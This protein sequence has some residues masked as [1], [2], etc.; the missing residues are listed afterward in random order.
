L[1]E[2]GNNGNALRDLAGAGMI[3]ALVNIIHSFGISTCQSL[4]FSASLLRVPPAM[5]GRWSVS[6]SNRWLSASTPRYTVLAS[7]WSTGAALHQ[8]VISRAYGD[9]I[10]V[11]AEEVTEEPLKGKLGLYVQVDAT[12]DLVALKKSRQKIY[13]SIEVH[14]S[15]ADT[16]RSLFDG[17][18]LYR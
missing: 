11:K 7:I 18:G 16:G 13:H 5:V 1:S 12:D 9:V 4:N 3:E 14:P 8:T 10:A 6:T 2:N 15:F 17:A